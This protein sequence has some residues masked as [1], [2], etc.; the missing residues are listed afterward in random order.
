MVVTVESPHKIAFRYNM[1]IEEFFDRVTMQRRGLSWK[2]F[3]KTCGPKYPKVKRH[4]LKQLEPL[5]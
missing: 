5:K 4:K 3:I 2:W 1:S